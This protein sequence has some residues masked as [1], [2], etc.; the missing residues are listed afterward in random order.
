MLGAWHPAGDHSV[1]ASVGLAAQQ[2]LGF[3]AELPGTIIG[4]ERLRGAKSPPRMAAKT[5][6]V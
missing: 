2:I 5:N 6:E 1:V 3:A 4:A